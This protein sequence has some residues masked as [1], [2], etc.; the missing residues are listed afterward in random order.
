MTLGSFK[1]SKHIFS[2][3]KWNGLPAA[4]SGGLNE[5]KKCVV[6]KTVPGTQWMVT[7]INNKYLFKKHTHVK[8][9]LDAEYYQPKPRVPINGLKTT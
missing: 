2:S 1:L 8:D 5:K 4:L 7:M 3:V 6:L 9:R